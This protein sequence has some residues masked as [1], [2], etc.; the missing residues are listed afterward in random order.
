MVPMMVFVPVCREYAHASEPSM[1][2]TEP[3]KHECSGVVDG[4]DVSFLRV[5]GGD[6]VVVRKEYGSVV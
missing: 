1:M 3:S 4:Y 5:I 6:K 2:L